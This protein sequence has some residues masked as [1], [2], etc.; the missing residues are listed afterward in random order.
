MNFHAHPPF[1]RERPWTSKGLKA[2]KGCFFYVV[3]NTN[4]HE[5]EDTP[6]RGMAQTRTTDSTLCRKQSARVAAS[7]EK[8]VESGR[9]PRKSTGAFNS[10][11]NTRYAQVKSFAV[12]AV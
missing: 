10:G 6:L 9:K 2:A 4:V 5:L 8:L 1:R 12:A 11:E 3:L 7:S